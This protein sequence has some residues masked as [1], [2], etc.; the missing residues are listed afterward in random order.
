LASAYPG[1]GIVPLKGES[2]TRRSK[3]LAERGTGLRTGG[4]PLARARFVGR[5]VG[6]RPGFQLAIMGIMP[7]TRQQRP[8]T[9][10]DHERRV[11]YVSKVAK[12][13][14]V[15]VESGIGFI[16]FIL[17]A[18]D[19]ADRMISA[20]PSGSGERHSFPWEC[21]KFLLRQS[22]STPQI[23]G[24]LTSSLPPIRQIP[25]TTLNETLIDDV[26]VRPGNRV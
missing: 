20:P 25:S 5:M 18:A 10:R 11:W 22:A 7:H 17:E 24:D 6:H 2:A 14:V 23:R 15:S 12:L 4:D 13:R 8:I 21:E 16:P 9:C 26:H 1:F 3:P 19:Y